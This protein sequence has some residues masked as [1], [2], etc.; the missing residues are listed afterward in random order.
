MFETQFTTNNQVVFIPRFNKRSYDFSYLLMKCLPVLLKPLLGLCVTDASV[1]QQNESHRGQDVKK[2]VFPANRL[3][4]IDN[5]LWCLIP[6]CLFR[7]GEPSWSSREILE[8]PGMWRSSNTKTTAQWPSGESSV[9]WARACTAS[10]STRREIW[11]PAARALRVTST[12][13]R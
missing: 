3:P 7:R 9:V 6:W 13:T 12:L 1:F 2:Y 10:T 5:I 4:C 11:L 8:W